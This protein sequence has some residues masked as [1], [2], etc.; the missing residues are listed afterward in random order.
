MYYTYI[1]KSHQNNKYYI[2]STSN[3]DRRLDEH[4]SGSVKSTKLYAPWDIYYF[5]KFDTQR[6]AILREI[7][8][9]AWKSRS[10][11]EKLKSKWNHCCARNNT[12]E[13]ENYSQYA[14][15]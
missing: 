9:K 3:L 1:L 2:G 14:I 8:I 5:E 12:I 11:I 10:M 7:Q 6:H 13:I 4:N 15:I